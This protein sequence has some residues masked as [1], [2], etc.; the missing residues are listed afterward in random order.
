MKTMAKTSV[1]PAAAAQGEAKAVVVRTVLQSADR[2]Q[3]RVLYGALTAE[4]KAAAQAE[5]D[6]AAASA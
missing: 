4:E 5:L 2:T 3:M 1:A 6:A